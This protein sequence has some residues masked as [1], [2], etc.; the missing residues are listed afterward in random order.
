MANVEK[1]Q[2]FEDEGSDH[3]N[4]QLKD[5]VYERVLAEWEDV[6]A[7]CTL[8]SVSAVNKQDT[9][10]LLKIGLDASS[11]EAFARF[12]L[13]FTVKSV[14][15]SSR[16]QELLFVIPLNSLSSLQQKTLP[17]SQIETPA[18]ASAVKEAGLSEA[19]MLIRL[20]FDLSDVGYVLMPV[21]S[22]TKIKPSTS[23]SSDLL[24]GLQSLSGSR[25]FAVYVR[26]TSF[27]RHGLKTVC[28]RL[29]AGTLVQHRVDL[30]KIYDRKEATVINWNIFDLNGGRARGSEKG[31]T[32]EDNAPPPYKKTLVARTPTPE[33]TGLPKDCSVA[34]SPS[35]TRVLETPRE[36]KM[37]P[38][39]HGLG[40]FDRFEPPLSSQNL[41][42]FAS[43]RKGKRKLADRSPSREREQTQALE[44]DN[45]PS[46]PG[47]SD[48]ASDDQI[49]LPASPNSPQITRHQSLNIQSPTREEPFNTP[50]VQTA[51]PL[52]R[53]I[54]P[55]FSAHYLA[56]QHWLT[57]A[58]GINP[59]LYAHARVAP[60]LEALG[61]HTRHKRFAEFVA[62]R[63]RTSA[64]FIYDPRDEAD[65]AEMRAARLY[66]QDIEALVLWAITAGACMDALFMG[67]WLE[68]GRCAREEV[69]RDKDQV[70]EPV[71]EAYVRAK[72]FLVEMVFTVDDGFGGQEEGT[73]GEALG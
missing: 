14:R 33:R 61:S 49:T 40:L 51:A 48:D 7:T 24:R 4:N 64:A 16:L 72:A 62:A 50:A 34:S 25:S 45:Q 29:S 6:G 22:L 42:I 73:G 12:S 68:M 37:T 63:A 1:A 53:E 26:P 70:L 18:I 66:T 58:L 46:P 23:V 44:S 69:R 36:Y 10:L 67:K 15:K 9:M 35:E 21:T 39:D 54:S 59:R 13:H 30:G 31:D 52:N 55:E 8:G 71:G 60:H 28:D 27:A 3:C 19:D 43:R 38:V 41:D 56:Y 11:G 47:V 20:D 57:R 65:E 17:A 5:I 2:P 32:R